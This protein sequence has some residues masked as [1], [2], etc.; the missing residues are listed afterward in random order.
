MGSFEGR[1]R[2]VGRSDFP[3]GVE[4]DLTETRMRVTSAGE[5][6]ADWRF[7]DIRISAMPNGYYIEAEDED[8]ILNV[9]EPGRFAIEIGAHTRGGPR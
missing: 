5:E 6:V 7:K 9:T 8:V 4:I 1:L 2:L 3:L